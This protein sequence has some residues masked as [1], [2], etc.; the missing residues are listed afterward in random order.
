L[1]H[2]CKPIESF[3]YFEKPPTWYFTD[4]EEAHEIGEIVEEVGEERVRV[5]HVVED[6]GEAAFEGGE[7]SQYS[8]V[9]E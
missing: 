4:Q 2:L 7:E 3:H 5:A 6:E 8:T 1:R 9:Q